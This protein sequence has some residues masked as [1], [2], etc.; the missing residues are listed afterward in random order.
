MVLFRLKE[1]GV[2]YD[3]PVIKNSF[4]VIFLLKNCKVAVDYKLYDLFLSQTGQT[5]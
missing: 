4:G 2:N 1:I 3:T 5:V